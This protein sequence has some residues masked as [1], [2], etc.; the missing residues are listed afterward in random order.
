MTASRPTNFF[1]RQQE[2]RKSCRNQIVLFV[3]AVLM[4][5]GVTTLAIR[6]AWYLYIGTQAYTLFNARSAE[7]YHQK[8]STF[9]F[10]D[11]AFFIFMGMAIVIVILTASLFKMNTLQKGGGA[12]AEMLGGRQIK[13]GTADPAERRLQNVVE[14]MA[15]ASGIPV[16][17]V[18]VLDSE[19][20]I[21]AFA[22]GLELSDAA[23]A[24]TRGALTHLTRDELQG[25]IAH[26][27]SH[28]LNGDARLNV[29]LIGILFGILFM[30]IVG[31]K[32]V[33]Q[34]RLSFRLGL[35]VIAGG[36]SLIVIGYIGTFAG[37]L[38][39]CAIS[40]QKELL[41]DASAVQFTRNPLGLAGALKKIGGSGFG[42]R[43]QSPEAGQASHLFFGESH[44][45]QLFA[46]F[47]ATHPPL[48]DRI[49]LLDPAF[50]G[51]FIKIEDDRPKA[52]PGYNTPFWGTALRGTPLRIP[53]GSPLLAVVP[54]DVVNRVG[55]PSQENIEQSRTL[56]TS[57][58]AEIVNAVKTPQGAACVIYALLMDGDTMCR[59]AQ[60]SALDR[61]MIL[62]GQ[63]DR[64]PGINGQLSG[65]K[66]DL[67]L[68]LI[69]L[70]MPALRGLTS[71]EKRNFLLILQSFVNADG[72]VNLFELSVL[73]ILD[74][75]LN[76]SEN[77]FKSVT[78]FSYSR[79]G[80]DIVML[81]GALAS[82][83]HADDKEKAENAFHAGLARIP[84][85][86]ARKPDFP[87]HENVSYAMVNKVLIHLGCA[88]FK[89]RESVIDACAHC[90]FAD[91][92][93]TAEEGD[94]LRVIALAL[95]CP[96][97]PFLKAVPGPEAA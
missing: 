89:I 27:F 35:P 52:L 80:L 93:V 44:P 62:Q 57:I 97:P 4:I 60:V 78:L 28:I 16:P 77:L 54:A 12:V 13:T 58:P 25:V 63:T 91:R 32:I 69:E 61:A 49:R 76:P 5:V 84:E 47:L 95:E 39:Q 18:Y 33:S 72:R 8:L 75:Y 7:S 92:L 20:G 53:P 65:L 50:D 41:A 34:G 55:H 67:R 71:M 73:W 81:L 30:G 83:G 23:V 87:F 9:E 68:P 29:Q 11:P 94:L 10:F 96:L 86:A 40:R 59:Q 3:F 51:K 43:I 42:S 74:R 45:D 36:V 66:Q 22:A 37:R 31:R 6:F 70:A 38:M 21:N 24:V 46:S 48:A 90:A 19:H 85:L 88:S 14:E 26:E 64:V 1:T 79:V 15:I 2:A 17:R 56:L 82:T